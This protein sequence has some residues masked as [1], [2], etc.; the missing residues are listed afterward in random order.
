MEIELTRDGREPAGLLF[1]IGGAGLGDDATERNAVGE[2][3]V[4]A[5][6]PFSVSGVFVAAA[7]E[8]NDDWSDLLS[9]EIYRMIQAEVQRGRGPSGIFGRSED[10]DSVRLL[11]LILA[12]DFGYLTHD[13][14]APD[15]D[16]QQ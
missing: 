15:N 12:C 14:G 11:C 10:S 4:A 7:A 1:G 16:D 9:I 8:S 5:Y 3:I 13:I 2:Q 6:S